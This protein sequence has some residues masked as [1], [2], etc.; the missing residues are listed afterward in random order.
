MASSLRFSPRHAFSTVTLL[1]PSIAH[2]EVQVSTVG[3]T[4]IQVKFQSGQSSTAGVKALRV[5]F[6]A[7]SAAGLAST[8]CW[9]DDTPGRS[10]GIGLGRRRLCSSLASLRQSRSAPDLKSRGRH[11]QARRLASPPVIQGN[12]QRCYGAVACRLQHEQMPLFLHSVAE[13]I[14]MQSAGQHKQRFQVDIWEQFI[15]GWR[16]STQTTAQ[17]AA[18]LAL[19]AGWND[20]TPCCTCA[21]GSDSD[22]CVR[23]RALFP[24]NELIHSRLRGP[25]KTSQPSRCS[26]LPPWSSSKQLWA[27]TLLLLYAN[28]ART[29]STSTGTALSTRPNTATPCPVSAEK[30]GASWSHGG[31]S[32]STRKRLRFWVLFFKD[33]VLS[34]HGP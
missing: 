34:R 33:S 27:S 4:S 28:T 32:I 2:A 12:H 18:A 15:N 11:G 13:Q 24:V 5:R 7:Q 17:L 19:T 26:F 14:N 3:F 22:D 23:Q 25:T 10:S 1:A 30:A 8:A 16:H 20:N 21:Q 31:T 6:T 9:S 29:P